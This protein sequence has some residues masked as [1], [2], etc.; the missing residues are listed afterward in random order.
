MTAWWQDLSQRE[1]LSLIALGVL[2]ALVVAVFGVVRPVA[3]W[4]SSA[5]A[6]YRQ[7][8]TLYERVARAAAAPRDDRGETGA[9]RSVLTGTA[10]QSGITV[11]T[12]RPP[13]AGAI[14]LS[15]TSPTLERFYDWL[16]RLEREHGVYVLEALVRP[17]PEGGGVAA[18]LT[19][20]EN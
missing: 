6:D 8:L 13:E 12:I 11:T 5:E 7:S 10:E 17:A 15:I 18:R 16:S 3:S 14:E 19:M 9:I 1:R 2:L 4:R 20:V